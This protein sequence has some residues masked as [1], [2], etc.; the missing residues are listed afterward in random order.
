MTGTLSTAREESKESEIQVVVPLILRGEVFLD[1]LVTYSTRRGGAS[2]AAPDVKAYI[3]K[4]PAAGPRSLMDLYELSFEEIVEFLA[5]LGPLLDYQ[6]NEYL[7]Q[8][9]ELS[10]ITSGMPTPVLERVYR[11]MPSVFLPQYIR[12]VA[13][14]VVGIRY[15]EGW[16]PTELNNGGRFSVRAF[17]PRMVNILAGNLPLSGAGGL[18]RAAILRSDVILKPP[19]NDPATAAAIVRTMRDMSPDHPV[20]RHVSVAYWKGGDSEVE[21]VLYDPSRIEKIFATGGE[22]SMRH[23]RKYLRPGLDLIAAD[24]KLSATF[25]GRGTLQ[26]QEQLADAARRL[27]L[28]IGSFNQEACANARIVYVESGTDEAGIELLRE[29]GRMVFQSMMGLPTELSSPVERFDPEMRDALDSLSLSEEWFDLI[30]GEG[31][32]GAIIV[33]LQEEVV[34]FSDLLGGRVANLV[35][36]D[37]LESALEFITN[38]TQTIGVYPPEVKSD[39]RDRMGIAGAQRIVTLG[40]ATDFNYATPQDGMEPLRRLCK[41]V[42][43]EDAPEVVE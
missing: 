2:F 10:R 37:S 8:A 22:A 3:G 4:L 1:N 16:V 41:W 26:T 18:L 35:P 32:E 24:P 9:F 34:D 31:N 12:D 40:H 30:G 43:D 38:Y 42:V 13:E 21:D 29:L 5:E 20:T 6:E 33:S 39:L 27:A 11:M 19:S 14:S 23:I 17:G 15:L 36:V 28:D 7:N 25:I